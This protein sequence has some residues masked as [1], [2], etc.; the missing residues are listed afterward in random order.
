MVFS[1]F[2]FLLWFLP[3]FLA[4]YYLAPK[5]GKNLTVLFF[6]L[7]FYAYG[8][9]EHPLYFFLIVG[10]VVL[11]YLLGIAIG[12]GK[13]KKAF[14]A[15]G[16]LLDFGT[17]FLFKYLDFTLSSVNRFAGT[18]L[19][20]TGW[21]LPIGISFFTFQIVS[22]LIDVYRGTAPAEKNPIDLGTYIIAFPQL[23]A[24]PIVK[25]DEIRLQ[26]HDRSVTK[27]GI[28]EGAEKFIIG[29][30]LKVLLANR[31]AGLWV[32]T[33]KIGYTSVSVPMAWLGILGYSLQL[34]F[35][36]YGY[37][38]MA[39]GLGKLMGF[40]FPENFR[41]PYTARS[42]TDFWRRW[43]MT[44][45]SWFREYVYIPLGGNR[46][47]KART[48]LNLFVVWMLTGIWHGAG[49]NF[50][51]WGLFLATIILLEKAFYGK[52]LEK[53]AVAG[54]LYMLL[55][56]PVSWLIFALDSL[57]DLGDYLLRLIGQGGEFVYTG[58]WIKNLKL[59]WPFLAAGILLSTPLG[60][61]LYEKC[62]G[63]W[64]MLPALLAILA[65][66]IYC[67]YRGLNDPFMYFRF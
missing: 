32:E 39:I 11:N 37:S 24:G 29:L 42:M 3:F 10:L 13:G 15:L 61:K 47:G 7:V 25:Y 16:L 4:T 12:R 6:S 41:E 46:K 2:P 56:I 66:A 1:G 58:D 45:G 34:Y 51:L 14:L 49:A 55:L 53:H 23:I 62:R 17:L 30:G 33:A 54:H 35:D 67:L 22:Y 64:I 8:C 20:L 43:H 40:D 21:V 38:L 65:G 18:S 36:F 26:L 60:K 31:L 59:F 48:Y 63:K 44:L 50:I 27:A 28:I 5:K 9:L 57:Q 52:F 19:P